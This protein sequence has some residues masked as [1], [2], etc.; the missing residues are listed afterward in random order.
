MPA[1]PPSIVLFGEALIDDFS[2][3]QAVGGAPFNVARHLAAFHAGPMLVTRIGNDAHGAMVRAEL[4]RFAMRQEGVQVDALAPTGRVLVEPDG[5]SHRFVILPDQAYDLIDA[6]P[7]LAALAY[8]APATFYFG[9]LAQR[10]ATARAT[11]AALL[12]ATPARRFLDLNLRD[13]QTDRNCVFASL[14][15]ADV[16]KVNEPELRD[17]F[18][19]F[20]AQAPAV[21][22]RLDMADAPVLAACLRLMRTFDLTGLLVTLGERGAVYLGADGTRCGALRQAD[23]ARLADTVGAGD[24]F[25]AIYLLG[26]ARG[27]P[28]DTTLQR[29]NQFAAAICGIAGAVPADSSFYEP[30]ITRWLAD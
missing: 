9:T 7:A 8:C 14:H 10:G 30:W 29:A 1:R 4:A 19:W 26:C 18:A 13:G 24:A 5:A 28:L 3:T 21:A 17:L 25:A 16:V 12:A 2:T 22:Q 23:V 11:L 27:W 15:E 20:D 6:A